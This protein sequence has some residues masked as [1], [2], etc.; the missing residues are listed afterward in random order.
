M[1]EG[2]KT[3][4]LYDQ[5]KEH[6]KFFKI[7]FV[8]LE[9]QLCGYDLINLTELEELKGKGHDNISEWLAQFLSELT[10]KEAQ[11]YL[12]FCTSYSNIP[13][14]EDINIS[15]GFLNPDDGPFPK[16]VACTRKL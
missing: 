2:L 13:L 8:Y 5:I 15:V 3:L 10:E 11:M 7:Y 12:K 4:Q 9:H 16:L 6:R 1:R 14:T